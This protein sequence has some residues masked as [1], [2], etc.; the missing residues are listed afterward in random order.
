MP[1]PEHLPIPDL[2]PARR[3]LYDAFL[4]IGVGVP[5]TLAEIRQAMGVQP[6][7]QQQL[8]KRI[9]EL[10]EEG[11]DIPQEG[12]RGKEFLYV[13]KHEFPVR[14]PKPRE[15]INAKRR[16][17]ILSIAGGRCQMC[18]RS[19]AA[20]GVKLEVDHRVPLDLGGDNEDDNL[21]A[22]C[23]ECNNGKKNFF[24]S[25]PKDKLNGV[26][27][28]K[29]PT[30]RIGEFLKVCG[31]DAPARWMIEFVA[32]DN[33][34][35]RRLRELRDVGWDY[36]TVKRKNEFGKTET[37]YVITKTAPWPDDVDAAIKAA[38]AKRGKKSF[39]GGVQRF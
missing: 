20:D 5:A 22:I 29:D 18:G 12:S 28:H 3:R 11:F 36:K 4:H 8:R 27:I 37:S 9:Q 25:L 24:K 14:P 17:K 10:E 39:R 30:R 35:Y 6:H 16:A 31:D 32:R 21:W 13:L 26:L 1:D 23:S 38:A 19:V 33:D 34:T 2:P 15:N 7:E